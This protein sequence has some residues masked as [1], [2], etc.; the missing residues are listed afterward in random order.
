MDFPTSVKTVF[1]KYTTFSGRA[2]RSEYWYFVLF[3]FIAI[4]VLNILD[5]ALF[6][7][8]LEG[9]DSFEPLTL[10]FQLLILVPS[11]AVGARRLHDTGRSGWWQLINIIP[12][13]GFIVLI[14]W[15]ATKSDPLPN[16]FDIP[17]L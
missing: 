11:L 6:A 15:F 9:E 1:Q 10:I 4:M 17:T 16:R 14:V 5:H 7:G 12:I 3:V 13:I 8:A 2:A